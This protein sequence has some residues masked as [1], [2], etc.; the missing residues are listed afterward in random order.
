MEV[1]PRRPLRPLPIARE[2]ERPPVPLTPRRA[3]G[4]L[5]LT[6]SER[7][8][9]ISKFPFLMQN[10]FTELVR[11]LE[12]MNNLTLAEEVTF[13]SFPA[14]SSSSSSDSP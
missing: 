1:S 14:P 11:T 7:S 5:P 12:N 13:G 4:K 10:D 3:R 2:I 8:D 9:I 6:E